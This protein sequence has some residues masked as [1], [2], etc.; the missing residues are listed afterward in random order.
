MILLKKI[1]YN[2]QNLCLDCNYIKYCSPTTVFLK[3]T[4]KCM[5]N[6]NFCSQGIAG[7]CEMDINK[8]KNLLKK[9]KKKMF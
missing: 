3:I 7:N 2:N 8:A 5:L 6:C 9:L 4:S 1:I